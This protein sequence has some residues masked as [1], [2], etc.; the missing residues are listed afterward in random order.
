MDYSTAVMKGNNMPKY[1]RKFGLELSYKDN[2]VFVNSYANNA[3]SLE[4]VLKR[5]KV[6]NIE[7]DNEQIEWLE[8]AEVNDWLESLGYQSSASA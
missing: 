8:S 7:L 6:G 2:H 1:L 4:V 5:H 3:A